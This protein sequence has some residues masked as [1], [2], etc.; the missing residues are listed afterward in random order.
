MI[1]G[2]YI[3]LPS[4]SNFQWDRH[5]NYVRKTEFAL[6]LNISKSTVSC[7]NSLIMWHN[8]VLPSHLLANGALEG[9]RW[10]YLAYITDITPGREY[11]VVRGE[12]YGHIFAASCEAVWLWSN[13]ST[14]S[15]GSINNRY[16]D[17]TYWIKYGIQTSTTTSK[18]G[19]IL[20]NI[21][22]HLLYVSYIRSQKVH[23]KYMYHTGEQ[24]VS[25]QHSRSG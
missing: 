6:L 11:A 10:T 7:F 5:I 21:S 3:K 14:V 17:A 24:R 15:L 19:C 18:A 12:R 1:S 22:K 23:F 4:V 25:V 20:T 16:I 8:P 13:Q 2:T 9:F